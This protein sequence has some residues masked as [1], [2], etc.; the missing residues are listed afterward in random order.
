MS[1]VNKIRDLYRPIYT[2]G[3][4]GDKVIYLDIAFPEAQRIGDLSN[5]SEIPIWCTVVAV[6]GDPENPTITIRY[7]NGRVIPTPFPNPDIRQP[8]FLELLCNKLL[9]GFKQKK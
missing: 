3:R 8:G 6:N 5:Y 1:L 9:N 7:E 2:K 4:V